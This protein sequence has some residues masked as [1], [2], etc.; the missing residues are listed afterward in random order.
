MNLFA[1]KTDLFEFH[2][3]DQSWYFTSSKK[4]LV[5][6]GKNYLPFVIGR[7]SIE[8]EDI[9][10]CTV[11]V[12]FAF[13]KPL[14]NATGTD[15]QALF[16][17]KIY[18]NG[19]TCTIRELYRAETLVIFR[20]RVTLPSFDHNERIMTLQCS[21]AE[22]YQNRNILTRKFQRACTNKI[23]DRFCGLDF[24]V[25]SVAVTV[26][27]VSQTSLSFVVNP[28]PALDENG[29]PVLD[30][31]GNPVLEV[32]SYPVGYFDRGLL[33]KD[34]IYTFINSSTSTALTLYRPHF[35]L[36][37][38]DVV[39]FAPGCDQSHALC[40]SKF[41]NNRRFMGFPFI[42]NSNPV[43]DQIIK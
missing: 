1:S 2:Y 42:P 18:F 16:I 14:L 32:K 15:L 24:N 5:Y 25:W 43:N 26:T 41:S 11:D 40:G 35:G 31:N 21:T 28:T 33:L 4:A 36:S 39:R 27:D 8:D 38:G 17:N 22:S 29:D 37:I 34:G 30:E 19:V 9:D 6:E 13:P 7:T 12:T 20:G 10:K 3:G 23:Y